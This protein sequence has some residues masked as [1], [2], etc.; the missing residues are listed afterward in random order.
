M[1]IGGLRVRFGEIRWSEG[2]IWRHLVIGGEDLVRFGGPR[3]RFDEI[4]WSEDE[5]W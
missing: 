3:V 2:E 4:L 1:I 5:I